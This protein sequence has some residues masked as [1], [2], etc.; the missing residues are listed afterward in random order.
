M[1]YA[2]S[3]VYI[4]CSFVQ[5]SRVK[6]KMLMKRRPFNYVKFKFIRKPYIN[7]NANLHLQKYNFPDTVIWNPW[8]EK[9]KEIQV[10]IS[11]FKRLKIYLYIS[12]IVDNIIHCTYS[13][14]ASAVSFNFLIFHVSRGTLFK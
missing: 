9:A 8:I 4:I 7:Y 1:Q 6:V 12:H 2:C 11:G 3:Y 13:Y 5:I 10:R 14:N